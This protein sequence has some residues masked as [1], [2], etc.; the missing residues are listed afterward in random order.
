MAVITRALLSTEDIKNYLDIDSDDTSQDSLIEALIN[1][2]TKVI[3]RHCNCYFVE[4][5][6]ATAESP[7]LHDGTGT[8]EVMTDYWPITE[9]T[10]IKSNPYD[11]VA[12]TLNATDYLTYL[13]EGLIKL[14]TDSTTITYFGTTPQEIELAYKAG[15]CDDTA[16]VP[17]DVKEAARQQVA[18]W[19]RDRAGDLTT[20]R[21]DDHTWQRSPAWREP[22][23]LA[24]QVKYI[25]AP[26]VHRRM[27]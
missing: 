2:V 8:D 6:V 7:E 11:G 10:Q 24:D 1:S 4:N 21:I 5:E 9:V 17:E 20:E 12:Y 14:R 13:S 26:Y 3:E 18:I 27:A 15:Y 25:V 16:T 19:L 22:T 23:N